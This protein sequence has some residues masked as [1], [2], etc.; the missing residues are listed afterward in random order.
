L[1]LYFHEKRKPE[2]SRRDLHEAPLP[3]EPTDP[4][5]PTHQS[6]QWH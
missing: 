6:S 1:L 4:T 3:S 2:R 5:V